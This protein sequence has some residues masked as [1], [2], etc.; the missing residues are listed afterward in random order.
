MN[1]KI[2]TVIADDNED[3]LEIMQR[4]MEQFSDFVVVERCR[5]G[6]EVVDSVV[7]LDPDV[8]ILD[9]NMPKLNGMEAIQSC[10]HI[11]KDV[12]FIFITGY[13]EYAAQAFE[14]S[15]IDYIVKP[16]E[17]TRL[18]SA[19]EKVRRAL[20]QN[21][22]HEMMAFQDMRRL[23]VRDGNNHY[24]I[25]LQDI[26]FIEKLGKKCHIHTI[27]KV[28][29]TPEKIGDIYARLPSK[30]FFLSHRSYIVNIMHIAH[31]SAHNQTFLAYFRNTD[32][33][34]HISKLKI[35][36][37]QRLLIHYS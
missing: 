23:I 36:E 30:R 7:R 25:L 12:L 15:A 35:D 16:I 6:E 13:D 10:L 18:Y 37:L 14:L 1:E 24:Y 29:T 34:A 5:N 9:I 27:D 32:K 3:A 21:K 31:I 22:V 26:L 4:Y 28:Y 33:Y 20:K 11:K 8:I 17:K 19:I 2:R